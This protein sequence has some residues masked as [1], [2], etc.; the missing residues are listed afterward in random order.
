MKYA[1][2][3]LPLL[4]IAGCGNGEPAV[5]PDAEVYQVRGRVVEILYDGEALRIDHERID[6]YMEAMRMNF[7]LEDPAEAQLVQ[8]GDLIRFEYVV[9]PRAQTI[10]NIHL[11]TP[12]TQLDLEGTASADTLGS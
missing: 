11:L 8:P 10:R 3:L 2:W 4:L 12:G 5:D 6:G 9:T 1:L 7:R